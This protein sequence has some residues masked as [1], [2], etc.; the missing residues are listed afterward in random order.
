VRLQIA[1]RAVGS[2]GKSGVWR[3]PGWWRS[4]LSIGWIF[5]PSC[6]GVLLFAAILGWAAFHC[7]SVGA[8]LAYLRGDPIYASA[9]GP[10]RAI[11]GD[12]AYGSSTVE[13]LNMSDGLIHVV[14]STSSCTCVQFVGLP[15]T[16]E[17]HCR[18]ALRV[19]AHLSAKFRQV[20]VV[21]LTDS[22]KQKAVPV[23]VSVLPRA[24]APK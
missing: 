14:G 2:G 23:S 6:A 24:G 20:E 22:P 11:V 5:L 13:V 18:H 12:P 17:P 8:G 3:G 9:D 10:I 19:A 7:G 15:A 4:S 21:L 16:I 1:N